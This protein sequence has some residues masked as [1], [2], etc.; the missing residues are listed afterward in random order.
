MIQH[1]VGFKIKLSDVESLHIY[2][3]KLKFKKTN[4]PVV[5]SEFGGYSYKVHD[6]IFNLSNDYG[7]GKYK[8]LSEYQ[9]AVAA[10]YK[11]SVIPLISEGLCGAIFTQISDVEDEINGLITYDRK[12]EKL[13]SKAFSKIF[14]D[15]N[16]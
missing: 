15:I 10:L 2:F 8:N 9:D 7:Y 3:K 6:H 16:K 4:R 14:N 13:D 5:I 1:Q 12:V 11:D